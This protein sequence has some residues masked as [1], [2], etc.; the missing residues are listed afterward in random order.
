MNKNS[1]DAEKEFT[2]WNE[3]GWSKKKGIRI[4]W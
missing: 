3:M 1:Y 4:I 2:R